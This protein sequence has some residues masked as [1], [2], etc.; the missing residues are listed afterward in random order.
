MLVPSE[1]RDI[2]SSF[3]SVNEKVLSR[4]IWGVDFFMV[5]DRDAVPPDADVASLEISANG[6]LRVLPRY[7]VENYLL[8]AG[9]IAEVFADLEPAESSLRS[10]EKVQATLLGI[11]RSRLSHTVALYVSSLLRQS[12]GNVDLMPADCHNK[13]LED[14]KELIVQRGREESV[15]V[16]GRLSLPKIEAAVDETWAKLEGSL[17]DGSWMS[18]FPGRPIFNI[19]AAETRL[20]SGRLKRAYLRTALATNPGVF[21]ELVQVFSSFT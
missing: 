4:T 18:L 8:N 17:T 16:A 21:D 7:H 14:V 15:R 3:A 10:E 2:I 6:R 1:G 12:V 20:G 9:V 5:C 11:A 13:T 19:F